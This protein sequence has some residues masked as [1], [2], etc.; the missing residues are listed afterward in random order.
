MKK[1]L[2][3]DADILTAGN[4]Y[5]TAREICEQPD[6]W[7]RA[8]AA[9]ETQ[10]ECIGNWLQPILADP[11]LR[12]ILT[13]AGSSSFVG[14]TLAPWLTA[15]LRRRVDAIST[16]DLVGNPALYLAEDVPTLMI[17]FARS[18]DSPESVASVV[19]ADQFLTSCRHLVLTCNPDGRLA[20]TSR[21][22]PDALCLLMPEGAN[23]R[24]FAMTSSYTSMLVYCAAIFAPEPEHLK[25]AIASARLLLDNLHSRARA[26]AER[27][28]DR[29]VVLG[30]GCLGATAREACLKCVELTN[31]KVT[32]APDT[33]LG[34]R[35]GPKSVVDEGTCVVLLWSADAY[36]ARYDLDLLLELCGDR[37][38]AG[39][40]VLSPGHFGS[41]S[42][43][44]DGGGSRRVALLTAERLK[45]LQA[46][47]QVEVI[48]AD[49]AA[50]HGA[51][52][53]DDFWMSLL[54]LVFCQML[55]F[56]K[57]RALGVSADNPCP[58]GEVNRVVRGVTI[59]PFPG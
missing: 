30:A 29:L 3:I 24:S 38:A 42:C 47:G 13:G 40:V 48:P 14:E 23:D 22:N 59:H 37:R 25:H 35:H 55:A 28:F 33:P 8:D 16:T 20:Q 21:Q 36:T 18:G 34:F 43:R 45:A 52:A 39:I 4:S 9:V 31:G 17:S 51:Q 6:V 46:K 11:G 41:Y 1:Y 58:S 2:G 53:I 15:K 10:R 49:P 5:W 19:L 44:D 26:L 57:S 32:V 27:R 12:M 54:Y 50:D 7:I 56:F